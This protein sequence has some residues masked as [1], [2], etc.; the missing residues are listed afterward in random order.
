MKSI[1]FFSSL[2]SLLAMCALCSPSA[3]AEDRVAAEKGSKV[4]KDRKIQWDFAPDPSL[5]DVLILGDS[6]SIGYTL[7][8]RDLLKDKANVFRPSKGNRPVNCSGTTRGLRFLDAW[9]GGRDW[10]V[11]HFNWGLHDLK[12]VKVAGGD[13]K[14]NDPKSPTQ[15][16]VETYA[17]NLEAIVEKLEG[18]GARL[19]F[20]TTTPVVEGTRDPLREPEAPVTY[21][22]AALKIME[23]QSIPVNDLYSF[24]LPHL[25]EWQLPKNVH[26]RGAGSAAL[27]KEVA[28]AIEDELEAGEER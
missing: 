14:S 26:F 21:N 6:I 12:H 2:L 16:T 7:Q 9:I 5:P 22:T 15:A 18:T 8:V 17:Q 3:S 11:I 23:K 24:S 27:A 25:K 10:S 1:R 4:E 13:A 20:A 19:V 28:S